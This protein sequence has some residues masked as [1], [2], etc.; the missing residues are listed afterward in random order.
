MTA[1]RK[2]FAGLT[3]LY[4]FLVA[5]CL[6]TL[7]WEGDFSLG[8]HP[9]RN[10]TK[11]A[12]E[13]SNPS[14]LDVWFGNPNLQ[15]KNEEGQ[16][17]REENRQVLERKFL[18]ALFRAIWTTLQIATL[19]SFLGSVLAFPLGALAAKNI[20]APRVL[21]LLS[22]SVLNVTRSIHTLVFGLFFVGIIGLGPMAGV[23]AIATHCLGTFGKLYAETIETLDMNSINAVRAVGASEIQIFFNAV[24]PAIL[25]QMIS[26]NLY[27]WEYN[28]RDSTVLGLIGAGGL[29]L[30]L[31]EATSLFQWGRL[32]TIL[33]AI[34]L[35]VT[36]FDFLSRQIRQSLL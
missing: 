29:G 34:V 15:Y 7:I 10:L 22:K 24:W 32:S 31:S 14:F 19:G 11:T 35:V 28:I 26:T 36:A 17:L 1:S 2:Q 20:H 18:G 23:L 8:R 25:P 6:G 12:R 27:V 3:G 21:A 16:V 4:L 33:L 13:M 30:L 5:I 9:W